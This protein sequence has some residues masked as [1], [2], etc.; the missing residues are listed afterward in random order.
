M[1]PEHKLNIRDISQAHTQTQT[2]L[3]RK[4]YL[5]PPPEMNMAPDE[6]LLVLKPLYGLPESGLYWFA[7]YHQHHMTKLGMQES[8]EDRCLLYKRDDTEKMEEVT[9]LQVDDSCGHGSQEFLA[10]E[11][12]ESTSFRCKPNHTL[13]KDDSRIFNGT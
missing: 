10:D 7:I 6:V 1:H 8:T 9:M 13:Q 12:K 5:E 11:E 2:L 3:E 4:V